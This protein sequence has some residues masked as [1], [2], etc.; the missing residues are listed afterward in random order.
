MTRWETRVSSGDWDAIIAE[1]N[2]FG[3]ALLPR[4]VT[5]AE[6]KRLRKLYDDDTLFRSTVNMAP[7]R[8]GAGQYRYFHAPYPEPVERLKQALYPRLLPIARDWWTKLGRPTPW[9]DNLDDW[10]DTC[11]AAGQTRSTALILKYGTNDW[12]ALH[13]DLYGDLVFPLQVVINLSDPDTEYTGGEF[14]LVEQR[15]RAQS[16]GTAIQLPHGHGFVFTTRDRPVRTTRG[17]S[18]SPVRHG[19]STVRSG[20]RYAMGLIFHDAA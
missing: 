5:P 6:A 13:Q 8:Y 12:N 19:L 11:H 17:W 10:L 3:G 2:E 15:F 20:E 1:V 16:R 9:P 4:L 7:K 18:A 14:L